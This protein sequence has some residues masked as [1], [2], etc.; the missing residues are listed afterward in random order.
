MLLD[1]IEFVPLKSEGTDARARD[2]RERTALDRPPPCSPKT[3]YTLA[4]A[5]SSNSFR[6]YSLL[7]THAPPPS[8]TSN[9]FMISPATTYNRSKLTSSIVVEEF[10]STFT[11]KYA[12]FP[13]ECTAVVTRSS[14][15]NRQGDIMKM[16]CEL[17]YD[18]LNDD[19]ITAEGVDH[20]IWR[21]STPCWRVETCVKGKP[22]RCVP[23]LPH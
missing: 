7:V 20:I 8:S 23:V 22:M 12:S 9:L 11:S 18:Q 1:V 4:T 21:F 19:S 5:V 3:I 2:V 16:Q 10:F 14:T 17:L 13:I 15:G 6:R